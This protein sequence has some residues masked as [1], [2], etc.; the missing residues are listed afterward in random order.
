MNGP[1]DD[2]WKTAWEKTLEIARGSVAEITI[3][4]VRIPDAE[5]WFFEGT[6]T[7][8]DGTQTMVI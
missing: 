8:N 2:Q 6:I 5:G 1:S 3:K 4:V 7:Y